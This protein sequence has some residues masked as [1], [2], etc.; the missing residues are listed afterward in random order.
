MTMRQ[1]VDAALEAA[2]P[3]EADKAA[4]ELA[5]KYADE[6]D[7]ADEGEFTKLGSG[8]LACLEALQMTP[9]ARALARKDGNKDDKPTGNK[10]DELRAARARK[11]GTALVDEATA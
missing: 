5:R 9:R 3:A 6:I 2:P 11:N 10:L 7:A 8:L 4:A 1:A